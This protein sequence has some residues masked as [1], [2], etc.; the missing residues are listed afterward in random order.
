MNLVMHQTCVT[1]IRQEASFE[2]FT[3]VKIEVE[4]FSIFRVD[5]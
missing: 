2:A 4:V 1:I 3:V 5:P